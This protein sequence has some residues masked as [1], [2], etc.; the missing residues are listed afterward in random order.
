M[1]GVPGSARQVSGE[2]SPAMLPLVGEHTEVRFARWNTTPIDLNAGTIAVQKSATHMVSNQDFPHADLSSDVDFASFA[3][4]SSDVSPAT[5]A[6]HLASVLF[7]PIQT[8]CHGRVSTEGMT[9]G[10]LNRYEDRLRLDALAEYWVQLLKP[11]VQEKLRM[12]RT[13][14][15]TAL[16]SLTVNDVAGASE[17]LAKAKNFRLAT[18]VAQLPL[19]ESAREAMK[20]QIAVWRERNDWSEFSAPIRAIYSLLAGEFSAVAESGKASEDRVSAFSIAKF[21]GW[22]WKQSFA[23]RLFYGGFASCGEAIDAYV[24]DV[25][26]GKEE[27]TPRPS[28]DVTADAKDLQRQDVLFSILRLLASTHADLEALFDAKNITGSYTHNR[29]AWQLATV[30]EKKGFSLADDKYDQLTANF[31]SEL[32]VATHHSLAPSDA[33][34]ALITAAWVLLHLR[35]TQSRTT[36]LAELLSRNSG[37]IPEPSDVDRAHVFNILTQDLSIPSPLVWKAKA[38][39]E[40]ASP[41]S[42]PALEA[43]WLLHADSVDDAHRVLVELVGPD[44][45]IEEDY[46]DMDFLLEAFSDKSSKPVDW[47]HGGAVY[48]A[49]S[50]VVHM[51]RKEK[52]SR[53]GIEAINFLGKSIRAMKDQNDGFTRGLRAKVA[54]TEME[55]LYNEE[56]GREGLNQAPTLQAGHDAMEVDG[57]KTEGTPFAQYTAAMGIVV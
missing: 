44:A 22:D 49:F 8:A 39:H 12:A 45:I 4:A 35:N 32:E 18:I 55:R 17:A 16:H 46:A 26:S 19:Q 6:W 54:V 28:W 41:E 48:E 15:E 37:A 47:I 43:L 7:D 38:Q 30:F 9:K 27:E 14:E 2:M 13:A 3:H 1:Y 53:K 29:Q 50:K 11:V 52:E 10:L 51:S 25:Q 5:Q 57:Q 56:A 33:D 42:N 34:D 23:V 36:A 20:Q 21:V 40:H 31:A 24:Q